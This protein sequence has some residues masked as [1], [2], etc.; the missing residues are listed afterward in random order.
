MFVREYMLSCVCRCVCIFVREFVCAFVCACVRVCVS[1]CVFVVWE[2]E[3][4]NRDIDREGECRVGRALVSLA[5]RPPPRVCKARLNSPRF[6]GTDSSMSMCVAAE[7]VCISY[8]VR[9]SVL[10]S[11]L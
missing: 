9:V 1:V 7:L 5:S 2:G 4:E 6:V 10:L 8:S 11:L 3:K